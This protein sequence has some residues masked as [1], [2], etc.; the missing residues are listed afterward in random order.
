VGSWLNAFGFGHYECPGGWLPG[1]AHQHILDAQHSLHPSIPAL[2][3][4]STS[5][6]SVHSH[7]KQVHDTAGL[8]NIHGFPPMIPIELRLIDI[9]H[10]KY[11]TYQPRIVLWHAHS[12]TVIQLMQA[13][14]SKSGYVAITS[15]LAL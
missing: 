1:I 3:S 13:M 5:N 10:H 2:K 8:A 7:T 12:C 9:V 15:I 14:Q 4:A 6:G 11:V